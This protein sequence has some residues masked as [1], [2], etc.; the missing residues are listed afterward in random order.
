MRNITIIS[1]VSIRIKCDACDVVQR[2]YGGAQSILF[3]LRCQVDAN[4]F[5]NLNEIFEFRIYIYIY[6][7]P[8][9]LPGNVLEV[10]ETSEIIV[11]SFQS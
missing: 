9:R 11:D 7:K 1:L 4:A 10:S 2:C 3:N 8:I 6:E 5:N